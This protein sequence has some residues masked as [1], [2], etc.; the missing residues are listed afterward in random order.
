MFL[1]MLHVDGNKR[2]F[3]NKEPTRKNNLQPRERL[4]QATTPLQ[5]LARRGEAKNGTRIYSIIYRTDNANS[6]FHTASFTLANITV[7][8]DLRPTRS[9][10]LLCIPGNFKLHHSYEWR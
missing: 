3:R 4:C 2:A 7:I 5:K 9:R 6:I 10:E 8:L 1:Q